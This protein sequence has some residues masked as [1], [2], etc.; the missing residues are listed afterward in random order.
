M[1]K[2]GITIWWGFVLKKI[3]PLKTKS[4]KKLADHYEMMQN[5]HMK[6]LFADDPERFKKFSVRFNDILVDYSKNL[7][8]A[9]TLRLLI[10]LAHEVDLK[11]ESLLI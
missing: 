8:S 9:K 3:N 4:W 1:L 7:I 10:G 2:V 5:I 6:H 11:D